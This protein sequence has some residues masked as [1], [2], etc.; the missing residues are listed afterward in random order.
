MASSRSGGDVE[1]DYLQVMGPDLGPL[2]HAL[3]VEL[4]WTHWR[5]RQFRT[6]FGD[7]S[8]RVDLLNQSAPLFFRI[9]QDVLFEDTLLSISRLAGAARSLG[10]PNLS[11][12]RL[13]R[14][15]KDT[16]LEAAIAEH[17]AYAQIDAA[18]AKDWRNRRIAH[19]DLRLVLGGAEKPLSSASRE[20]V[21]GSLASLRDT[22]NAVQEAYDDS[23]TAYDFQ[24]GAGDA[25]SLLYV[26]RDGM[27]FDAD[28]RERW[29]RGEVHPD[30]ITPPAA[31]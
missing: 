15:M 8:S 24:P 29:E 25:E 1:A 9:V 13:P 21:D 14:L 7:K 18:F 3:Y 16:Q 5:W 10:K 19:R 20:Q 22:L 2:F 17:V 6:L 27:R 31:V 26:L 28:R 23:S 12:E 4:T 30:D 11:I